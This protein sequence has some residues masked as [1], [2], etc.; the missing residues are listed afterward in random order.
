[1]VSTETLSA[2]RAVPGWDAAE[3][4]MSQ[5][6]IP[7]S[8]HPLHL[9]A[10]SGCPLPRGSLGAGSSVPGVAWSWE[11]QHQLSVWVWGSD[12]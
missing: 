9:S 8:L 1:M 2:L 3:G 12:R 5:E 10:L 4:R 11:V 7:L 6:Q